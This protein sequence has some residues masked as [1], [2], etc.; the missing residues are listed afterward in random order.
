MYIIKNITTND[1][2]I[3]DLRITLS[4][5]DQIDL[6]MITSRF[7]IDQSSSLKGLFAAK[8]L[9]CLIKNDTSGMVQIKSA[10]APAN[11][12]S[13]Q[14]NIS[15]IDTI[16]N[17][18]Q[19]LSKKIEDKINSQQHIDGNALNQA[20]VVMQGL[21]SQI[22]KNNPAEQKTTTPVD[23]ISETKAVDINSRTINRLTNN[24]Q[25][26]VKHES[27]TTDNNVKDNIQELEG[28]L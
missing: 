6:D 17:L 28:L 3:P 1:V 20:L 2:S 26:K 4:P 14:D 5:G 22:A 12:D 24:V 7:Y 25:S 23:D 19:K 13:Y 8:K 9:K 11:T 27:Q 10:E 16:K 15:I 21:L 18:E